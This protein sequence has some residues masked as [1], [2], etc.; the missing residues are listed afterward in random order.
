MCGIRQLQYKESML[1]N[2]GYKGLKFLQRKWL[3]EKLLTSGNVTLVNIYISHL[4]VFISNNNY[5]IC[6]LQIHM[7]DNVYY[8]C[9][10]FIEQLI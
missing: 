4:I 9:F 10:T 5:K 6:K 2:A 3:M 7:H 8:N 1:D